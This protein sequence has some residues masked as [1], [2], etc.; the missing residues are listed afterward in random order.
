MSSTSLASR[1]SLVVAAAG[2]YTLGLY[3][4]RD[5]V[6]PQVRN[7]LMMWPFFLSTLAGLL[8]YI[9]LRLVVA[10]NLGSGLQAAATRLL[11]V[12]FVTAFVGLI[13]NGQLAAPTPSKFAWTCLVVT[14]SSLIL[15]MGTLLTDVV[16]TVATLTM[17]LTSRSNVSVVSAKAVESPVDVRCAHSLQL[18]GSRESEC[19]TEALF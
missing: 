8:Y 4:F 11:V 7:M 9:W 17:W 18:L 19:L 15:I 12:Y 3:A 10:S 13:A 2:L 1:W 6:S 16:F 5:L 14:G